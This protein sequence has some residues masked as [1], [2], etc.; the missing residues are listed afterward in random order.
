MVTNEENSLVTECFSKNSEWVYRTRKRLHKCK[1]V[2]VL[3]KHHAIKTYGV[4]V[5]EV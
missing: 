2:L 1:T 3:T 5:V 4:W